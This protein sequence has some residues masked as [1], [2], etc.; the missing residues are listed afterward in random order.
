MPLALVAG[1]P[2]SPAAASG[3][4]AV[5]IAVLPAK[6]V[7]VHRRQ[8]L[9]E[10]AV[11]GPAGEV[12]QVRALPGHDVHHLR[13]LAVAGDLRGS[14]SRRSSTLRAAAAVPGGHGSPQ[15][16]PGCAAVGGGRVPRQRVA[17]QR[18]ASRRCDRG[19]QVVGSRRRAPARPCMPAGASR[20]SLSHLHRVVAGA[21]AGGA[22]G[23]TGAFTPVRAAA[24]SAIQPLTGLSSP[25]SSW[26]ARTR[27]SAAAG[28]PRYRSSSTP[29]LRCA[30]GVVRIRRDAPARRRVRASANLPALPQHQP[31]LVPGDRALAGAPGHGAAG[32]RPHRPG[33]P[34]LRSTIR[35]RLIRRLPARRRVLQFHLLELEFRIS[36]LADRPA[37][38]PTRTRE[39]GAPA[40]G[41][42]GAV[43]PARPAQR[44]SSVH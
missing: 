29:R 38:R 13:Q 33:R 30:G 43:A 2:A 6:H 18:P 35:P 31:E 11:G 23:V 39:V 22:A 27:G 9:V 25:V 26:Y 37:A 28:S 44:S 34:R 15:A 36:G 5:E 24:A 19:L 12:A 3:C 40:V 7:T 10:Q 17:A 14:S 4:S 16:W 20:S 41:F 1:L 8:H 32:L 42:G 21:G